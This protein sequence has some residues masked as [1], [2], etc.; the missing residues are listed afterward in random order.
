MKK[1]SLILMF[2]IAGLF[3]SCNDAIDINQPGQVTNPAQIYKNADD[4]HR[5]VLGIYALI[6]GESEIEFGSVFTDEVALGTANGGQGLISGEY[7]F[8][9]QPGNDFA[10]STWGGYYRVINQVNRLINSIDILLPESPPEEVKALNK[11]KAEL[12][13]LRAY[14][15]YKLFAYF[16]PDYE[17]P[18]GLSIMKL[19]FMQTDD[20][21]KVIGR[22]TVSEI[23]DFILNDLTEAESLVQE[24]WGS[25][26]YVSQ[27]LIDGIRTKLYS[28]VGDYAKVITSAQA[29][30]ADPK[31]QI[32]NA[33][34]FENYFDDQ[35][36][37][38][39]VI[40]QL[41]RVRGNASVASAWYSG[42]VRSTGQPFYEM[43]RS[44]YNELDKL[45]PTNT[46]SLV[47]VSRNDVRYKVN[48]LT[49]S[50]NGVTD[51]N[52]PNWQA[53][54]VAL[55][56]E[57]LTQAEYASFD[58]LLIGKYKG[59]RSQGLPL[60]N[61]IPLLRT[62]DIYLAMAEARAGQGIINATATTPGAMFTEGR[63]GGS[64]QAILFYL[65]SNRV[66]D[67]SLIN[68]PAPFTNVQEAWKAILDERRV[69]FAFEGYRYLDMKRLGDKAGSVGFDRYSKDCAVNGACNLPAL[70][71]KLTLPIP[72]T[73]LNSN[74]IIRGQQNPGY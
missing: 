57:S 15:N 33:Q 26:I 18:S 32:A 40:F 35:G 4:V 10:I 54:K 1:K 71:H 24:A 16:T 25:N 12:L 6:P 46:D 69:E 61:N 68:V 22:S 29:L 17:N 8:F 43:G 73:E 21:S 50:P 3:A 30:L 48:L 67:R 5:G 31:N 11:S 64:V 74:S 59:R 20:Y 51:P 66:F 52:S 49:V 45:D 47:N 41:Q 72:T 7:G 37:S 9:M 38:K 28:F 14:A 44:L 36:I 39:E 58:V 23:S 19:D 27:G 34:E 63:N 65:K 13:V 70:S 53:S 42:S 62:A 2:A 60:Q 55:D 56:Y